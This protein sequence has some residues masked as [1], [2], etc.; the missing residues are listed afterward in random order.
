MLR[1]VPRFGGVLVRLPARRRHVP[2]L[3][4]G[5]AR[6]RPSS[7]TTHVRRVLRD[8]AL[9]LYGLGHSDM[10]DMRR[11][12]G[13]RRLRATRVYADRPIPAR[14][15]RA[16][17]S[18]ATTRACS[19]GNTQPWEFV[20][21]TDREVKVQLRRCCRGVGRRRRAARAAARAARRRRRT[22]GHR[23][24]GDRE[25]RPC[26]RDRVRVL[27][28]RPRHPHAG[29]VRGEPRRHA[30]RAHAS[31]PAGAARACSRRART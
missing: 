19:S 21:V 3:H 20:V 25:H 11:V 22:T 17:S 18:R 30:A 27:E 26:R 4:Q 2:R 5:P 23:A 16:R 24:R 8:N 29:R 15:P 1:R 10:T 14:R 12:R 9:R 7:T 13:D 6:D 31:S 28:P